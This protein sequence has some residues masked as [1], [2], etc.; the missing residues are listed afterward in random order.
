MKSNVGWTTRRINTIDAAIAN[1]TARTIADMIAETIA[2]MIAD[3][4]SAV[5]AT[6]AVTI[7]GSIATAVGIIMTVA[8]T[9]I[10]IGATIGTTAADPAMTTARCPRP[11]GLRARS[12]N[13]ALRQA[14]S[15][16]PG[17]RSQKAAACSYKQTR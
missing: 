3:M 13:A 4:T 14:D 8:G 2:S 1:M 6:T 9:G 12:C 17:I 10:W 16:Q 15:R 5:I 11:T 7:A